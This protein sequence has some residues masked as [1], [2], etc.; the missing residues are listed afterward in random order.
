M[1]VQGKVMAFWRDLGELKNGL[2]AVSEMIE[3][4]GLIELDVGGRWM[5]TCE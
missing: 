2:D 4:R 5:L 3:E 1:R